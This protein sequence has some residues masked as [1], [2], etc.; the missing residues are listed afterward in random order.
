MAV[1]VRRVIVI[2]PLCTGVA[3]EPGY[4]ATTSGEQLLN[5]IYIAHIFL[6]IICDRNSLSYIALFL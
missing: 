1:W 2:F 4:E 6:H 5:S 3:S